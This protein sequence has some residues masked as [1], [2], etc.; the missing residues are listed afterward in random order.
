MNKQ[1]LVICIF[2]LVLLNGRAA[3]ALSGEE[4]V[5]SKCLTCHNIAGKG[6]VMAS[7]FSQ[8]Y[9]LYDPTWLSKMIKA[10]DQVLAAKDPIALKLLAQYNNIPM[11]NLNL[12]D[13]EVA[14]VLDYLRELSSAGGAA[15]TETTANQENSNPVKAMPD[16]RGNATV[17][18]NLFNGAKPFTHKASSCIACHHVGSPS[19]FGGGSL[20]LNLS[21]SYKKYGKQGLW[22]MLDKLPFPTMKP[23]YDTRPLTDEEKVHLIA[24]FE[25]AQK[26]SKA[27]RRPYLVFIFISLVFSSLVVFSIGRIWRDRNKGVREEFLEKVRGKKK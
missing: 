17:G 15:S 8:D 23:I 6:G 7:D 1:L 11:P 24:Y 10:P 18:K 9:K 4:I 12:N 14:A 21:D 16:I 26:Q 2:C 25:A 22:S 19:I 5:K 13:E 20:G 3:L 27:E